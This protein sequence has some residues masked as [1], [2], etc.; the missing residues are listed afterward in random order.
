M[1]KIVVIFIVLVMA[2]PIVFAADQKFTWV[3]PT[4]YEDN[5]PLS[6]ADIKQYDLVC[7]D[8]WTAG[9]SNS[10]A[11]RSSAVFDMTNGQHVCYM[12]TV[13]KDGQKSNHSNSVT[14]TVGVPSTPKKPKPAAS[15]KAL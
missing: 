3:P 5:S 7:D 8:V 9:F 11:N 10:P 6:N 14:F 13:M 4:Q 2:A 1:K 15:L 12:R